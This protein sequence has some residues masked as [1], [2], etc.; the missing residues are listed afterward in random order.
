[1]KNIIS[2]VL[3]FGLV[4]IALPLLAQEFDESYVFVDEKG[5]IIEN[6]ATVVRNDVEPFD[7][8]SDVIYSG[9][10]VL[11]LGGPTSDH[12][13]M[14]Y[15]IERI[16]NGTYQICFPTTC[17]MQTE[18]GAYE[19]SIGQLMG[20]LQ[21]IQ[22]EWF[23]VADGECV[24]TLTIEILTK[25]GFFPPTYVHKA[26]GPS[27]TLHFIKSSSASDTG[28]D[29]VQIADGVYLVGSILYIASGVTSL[30]D[31][32][33]NP[34]EIYCYA[35]IPPTCVANT[36]SGYAAILHVPVAGMVSYFT[37]PYWCN[38][39]NIFS[40]AIEPL[41]VSINPTEAEVETGQHLSLTATVAP[42]DATPRT[43]CWFSTDTTV[44][45]V[46]NG[47]VTAVAEGECDIL[48]ACVDKVAVCHMTVVS[49]RV[50]I[51][52]DKHE[53]RLL[54]NHTITLTASCSPVDVGL[55]VTSSNPGVAIPRLVNGTIMVV[56]VSEGTATIRVNTA[57]GWG[58][59][60]SCE[61]TVYTDHGDVNS[62]GY[63]NISDVTKLIDYLLNGSSEG[64]GDNNA[65]TNKD[66]QVNISDVTTLIDYLLSEKWPWSDPHENDWVDLG[67]PSGTLWA[68]MNVGANSP[69]EYGDYF[70]WGET[71]PKDYY[72]WNTY[73]WCN[74]SG[75]TLTKYCYNSYGSDI[76]KTELD[77][78]DDAAYVIWGSSWRMPSIEQMREL[79]EQ[80]TYT[81]MTRNGV[82]GYLVT[83]PNGNTLFLPAAG[84]RHDGSFSDVGS[85]GSYW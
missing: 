64:I 74:G 18:A 69:E 54:P 39:N 31:L 23:P 30:G 7:E 60:D 79:Y 84:S 65:D 85:W 82:N 53:A 19:T 66:G 44:A 83:G 15:V 77:S 24:V 58:N 9:I 72:H 56:G 32:Q 61:V 78:E 4:L 57:D 3:L 25:Q 63:V 8:V 71:A 41:S 59:P 68:T 2:T 70:A 50:T 46:S 43:V 14:N 34:S 52:L 10:S 1:M 81:W 76:D 33:V 48:A 17:N 27:V 11:N 16:D 37:A 22:S 67:L 47:M 49:P 20:D 40:D 36:F 35:S 45:T 5:N 73:K 26:F 6:G 42:A 12:I 13:K 29:C 55:V 28:T 51:T 62:D 38:F 80:C 75:T 21:D